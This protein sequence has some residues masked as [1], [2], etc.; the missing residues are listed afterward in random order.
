MIGI[1]II[2]IERFTK[3]SQEDFSHWNSVFT[4]SE[5]DYGFN[6]SNPARALAG[7]FS[8]KESVMKSVGDELMKQFSRIQVSHEANG[9]PIIEIDGKKQDNIHVSISHDSN[10]AVAVAI[11]I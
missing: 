7:I 8:A 11:Q 6:A 1:D 9:K 3:L 4:Q 5:W 2:D 10:M